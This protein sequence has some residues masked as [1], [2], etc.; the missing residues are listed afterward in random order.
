MRVKL[1]PAKSQ[2]RLTLFK[3]I[4]LPKISRM[5]YGEGLFLKRCLKA[6]VAFYNGVKCN[7]CV[8]QKY[9]PF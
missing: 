9:N 4:S 6:V 1:Y 2:G 3:L 8:D 7:N 5:G